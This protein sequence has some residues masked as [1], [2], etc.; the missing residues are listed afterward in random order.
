[1]LL[2]SR[3][4]VR[5]SQARM[6]S[7]MVRYLNLGLFA[8]YREKDQAGLALL[9]CN[10]HSVSVQRYPERQYGRF[11]EVPAVLTGSLLF[12]ENQG[13]LNPE[14]PTRNP[15]LD[16]RRLSRAGIDQLLRV[17]DKNR[18]SPGGSTL[19]TQIEK[20]RHSPEGRTSTI[21]EKFRQM[22]S[23]AVRAYLAGPDTVHARE[24]IVVDYLN[25]VP[26]SAR[27]SVGEIHGIGDGLWYWYGEDFD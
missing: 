2:E 11:D 16:L 23:A 21:S 15:A 20:Y 8:P 17:V 27:N 25:T 24:Q 12:V 18:E 14:F 4:F 26:L 9:D 1:E 3:G 5:K 10:D 22:G 7:E 13:L 6:S 19:A